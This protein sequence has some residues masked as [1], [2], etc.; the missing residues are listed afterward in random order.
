MATGVS[1]SVARC[2]AM[3]ELSQPCSQTPPSPVVQ[4]YLPNEEHPSYGVVRTY[5]KD[6]DD[7]PVTMGAATW[8]DSGGSAAG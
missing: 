7:E 8:L 3:L 2:A 5:V 6:Y 1:H 4:V